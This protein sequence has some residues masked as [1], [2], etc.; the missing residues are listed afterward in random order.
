MGK[1]AEG[2]K[3]LLFPNQHA[4]R[5]LRGVLQV[6]GRV[7]LAGMYGSGCWASSK[8]PFGSPCVTGCCASGAGEHL[9]KG[10]AAREC[11]ISS[12]LYAPQL[13]LPHS[14]VL[15][16]MSSRICICLQLSGRPGL[17]LHQGSP[18]RRP[19]RRPG[20][21]RHWRSRPATRAGRR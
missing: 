12:S 6:D 13:L 8:D 1:D 14:Y 10:F 19:G 4:D 5:A 20:V 11:C 2:C 9:M 7:G 18:C 17:C 16:E 3:C 15:L 21:P